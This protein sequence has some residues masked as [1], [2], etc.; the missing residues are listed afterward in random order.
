[1]PS[2]LVEVEEA[3]E[4]H[5]E[6]VGGARPLGGEAP[7]VGQTAVAVETE[8]GLRVADV[9]GEEHRASESELGRMRHGVVRVG[10]GVR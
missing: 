10:G 9:D 8:R 7:V 4:E 6:L 1:M 5:A 2:T 3:A